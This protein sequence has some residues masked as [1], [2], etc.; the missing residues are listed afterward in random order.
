MDEPPKY[1]LAKALENARAQSKE[2]PPPLYAPRLDQTPPVSSIVGLPIPEGVVIRQPPHPNQMLLA[3][4][5]L[6][7]CPSRTEQQAF[8]A[9]C[10]DIDTK[11]ADEKAIETEHRTAQEAIKADNR[12]WGFVDSPELI[13]LQRPLPEGVYW[14]DDIIKEPW[15]RHLYKTKEGL[16]KFIL[17]PHEYPPRLTAL[18]LITRAGFDVLIARKLKIRR[19]KDRARKE[20]TTTAKQAADKVPEPIDDPQTPP[21]IKPA[22]A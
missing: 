20:Q 1:T 14:L 8:D 9:I 22:K 4:K 5:P 17:E 19:E 2:E 16:I 7:R 10:T 6:E 12:D 15:C 11:V 13:A 21:P 3:L 18:G